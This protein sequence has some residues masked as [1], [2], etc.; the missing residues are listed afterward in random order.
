MRNLLIA[1]LIAGFTFTGMTLTS[2]RDNSTEPDG[3]EQQAQEPTDQQQGNEMAQDKGTAPTSE[4][5]ITGQVTEVKGNNMVKIKDDQGT[6][7]ELQVTD[8]NMLQDIKTG[9]NV[10]VTLVKGK[11]S[12]IEKIEG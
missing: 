6:T 10:K 4:N 9:D 3:T 1:M 2:C 12:S 11:A 8:Q 5:E 7:Y